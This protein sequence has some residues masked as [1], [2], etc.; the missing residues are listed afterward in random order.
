M[1]HMIIGL[2][3]DGSSAQTPPYIDGVSSLAPILAR[4]EKA[5][6]LVVDLHDRDG[7]L[8]PFSTEIVEQR[9][10]VVIA[11]DLEV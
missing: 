5:P 8:L 1:G 2:G 10:Q 6:G 3:S 11:R 4:D 7:L 9:R